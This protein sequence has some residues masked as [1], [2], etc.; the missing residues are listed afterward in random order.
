LDRPEGFY[1]Y[2]Y[3]KTGY[4]KNTCPDLNKVISIKEDYLENT[5]NSEAGDKDTDSHL[6]SNKE[7]NINESGKA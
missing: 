4:I 7:Y 6:L 2:N 1:Y 3:R 5:N